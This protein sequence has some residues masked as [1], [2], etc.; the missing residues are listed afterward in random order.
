MHMCDLVLICCALVL[1]LNA[2]ERPDFLHQAPNGVFGL[3]KVL[4]FRF[5]NQ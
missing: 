1:L 2:I 4:L 3:D 5:S